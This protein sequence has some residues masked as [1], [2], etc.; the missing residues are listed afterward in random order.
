MGSITRV[1]LLGD[2][3]I[4]ERFLDSWNSVFIEDSEAPAILL[5]SI[6]TYEAR[7]FDVLHMPVILFYPSEV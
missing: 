1:A 5:F 7:F 3:Y 6:L 2:R 4:C